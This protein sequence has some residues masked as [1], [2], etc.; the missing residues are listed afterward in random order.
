[1]DTIITEEI[2]CDLADHER[3]KPAI[4]DKVPSHACLDDGVKRKPQKEAKH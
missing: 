3:K 2:V 4:E 1:M